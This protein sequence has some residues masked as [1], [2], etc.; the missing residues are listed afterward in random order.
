M[1]KRERFL[2]PIPDEYQIF[3]Q[4]LEV[5]GIQHRKKA[6]QRFATG[7]QQRLKL[8]PE[9]SNEYD[10]NAIRVIGVW[11]DS[12]GQ[13]RTAHIGYLNKNLARILTRSGYAQR[14]LARLEAICQNERDNTWIG[15]DFQL[16]GPKGELQKYE[17]LPCHRPLSPR[18]QP[19]PSVAPSYPLIPCRQCEKEI[20][21]KAPVCPHCG[22]Y[23]RTLGSEWR[24]YGKDGVYK[25]Y[26]YPSGKLELL[27]SFSEMERYGPY[28]LYYEN[29]QLQQKGTYKAGEL[30]GPFESYDENGQ[31]VLKGTYSVWK[32]GEWFENGET[33]TY[34]PCPPGLADGN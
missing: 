27:N 19:A 22:A 9:P 5:V 13:E 4:R 3:E 18:R 10:P 6:A 16:L 25:T 30:D 14:V 8:K 32:C 29:G 28:E 15:V 34:P 31:L 23:A 26:Y 2:D 17:Q 7:N 21:D 12:S 20:S 33:V 24:S 1:G 11:K